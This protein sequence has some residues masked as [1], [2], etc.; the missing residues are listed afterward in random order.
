MKT[1]ILSLC[2][3]TIS[4]FTFG[5]EKTKEKK[6]PEQRAEMMTNHLDETV[7]LTAEQRTKIYDLNLRSAQKAASIRKD[8]KLTDE[9]RHDKMKEHHRDVK[10]QVMAELT[11]DQQKLLKEKHKEMRAEHKKHR[12]DSPEDDAKT[13][14]QRAEMMTN[15]LDETVK[16]TAEQRTKISELNLKSAQKMTEIRKDT[17]LSDEQLKEAVK[18]LRAETKKQVSA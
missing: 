8:T 10:K 3:L 1:I 13:P 18:K 4:V 17:K 16:L 12:G 14:E 2:L 9:Q 11:E 7:K 6:T 5:Q 15:R